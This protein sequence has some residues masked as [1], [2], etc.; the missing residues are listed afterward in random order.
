MDLL[1]RPDGIAYPPGILQIYIKSMD[2]VKQTIVCQL[3]LVGRNGEILKA[4][5]DKEMKVG[6]QRLTGGWQFY[7]TSA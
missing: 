3:V 5:E 1:R 6:Q 7:G 2:V 4:F